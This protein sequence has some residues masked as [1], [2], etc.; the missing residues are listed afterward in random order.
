MQ[1]ERGNFTR[2]PQLRPRWVPLGDSK[3]YRFVIKGVLTKFVTNRGSSINEIEHVE[4]A[5]FSVEKSDS[6]NVR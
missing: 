1:P 6:E 2:F 4:S 3:K 5:G